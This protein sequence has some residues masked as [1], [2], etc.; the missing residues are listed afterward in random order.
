[1]K[2]YKHLY[3]Q[4]CTFENLYWAYRDARRGKRSAQPVAAF[5]YDQES[6]LLAL[7]EELYQKTYRPG[8]YRHFYIHEPKRRKISAAPFRDRV[9]HHALCRIIEPIFERYFIYDSYACRTGKGTHRALDRCQQFARRFRYVLQGD[10]LQFFP[11]IDH[12]ILRGLLARHLRDQDILWLV[13][14]ILASGAGILPEEY[15]LQWFRGD[16]LFAALRPRG[17]PIGNLTSQFWANVY[18]NE[19]DQFVK[20]ELKC[21]AYIRYVDDFLMFAD[22]KAQLHRWRSAIIEFLE[23]LRLRLHAE[24]FRVYPVTE[25]IP[26]LGFRV[27]PTHRRLKRARAVAFRHCM[28]GLLREYA[29]GEIELDRVTA[30]V[31]GWVNHA[32][33]GDTFGLR[34]ALL[35]QC[36]IPVKTA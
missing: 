12:A 27:F 13:E 8:A 9:V 18:L 3:E 28:K 6:N 30:S 2:S 29:K 14:Q 7:Q 32:S 4:V 23:R 33:H 21:N 36:P 5:E 1:M 25:A 20:R 16:D 15:E 10:V 35:A 17:L 19:L 31:Q 22:D 24:A 34:R 26:F 11:S